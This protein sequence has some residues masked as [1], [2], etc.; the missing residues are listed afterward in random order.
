VNILNN[1]K[2]NS[3][4]NL[5][6]ENFIN[7]N[8]QEIY[9]FFYNQAQVDLYKYKSEIKQY[10]RQS[11]NQ[12]RFLNCSNKLNGD[13]IALIVETC[14]KLH[15]YMEFKIFYDYLS[16]CGY[17][18]GSRLESTHYYCSG[19]KKFDDYYD[20]YPI[21]LNL[22]ENAYIEEEDSKEKLTAT[23]INFYLHI[24]Y[25]FGGNNKDGVV[26]LKNDISNKLKEFV[27]LDKELINIIFNISIDDFKKA[28]NDIIR[29]LNDYLYQN[30]LI[31][32]YLYDDIKIE[33]SEY[34]QKLQEVHNLTFD[35]IFQ[36]SKHYVEN[37]I[38][39]EKKIHYSLKRG[40]KILDEEE[41][42]YQ[43][44]KSF[45]KMHKAK[46]YSSF[47]T[48]INELNTQTINIIDWGCG[49]A[50]ATSLLIDYIKEK[51]LKI[52]I[53]NITLIEPSQL[54]LSR[55]LLHID[56]LKENPIKIRAINKDIDCLEINDLIIENLNI[57]L[58]LFSNIL[59]V[60][61]FKL[62]KLFLEKVSSSQRGMNYFIC[63]SPNIND[64]RNARLD[65]FYRYFSDNF[66]TEL[67]S[68][69]DTNIKD[70]SRY[71]K[72]FKSN[73]QR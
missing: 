57:T 53:S 8:F 26:N 67:I 1:L 42:L 52:N 70:Y 48:I 58:H 68:N 34:S 2:H 69:R 50:L 39:D 66:N 73:I 18:L 21:I 4:T 16:K 59:D 40:I 27:S 5:Q 54:A 37:N 36:I 28:Y 32:C 43:Y 31:S 71:E 19:I 33:V 11:K 23:F 49:Q 65:M 14:E 15:L 61:F 51:N 9:D 56:V 47:D 3:S 72:I 55:G 44:I 25:N 30:D 60:E 29:I 63:V 46:L 41:E 7:S 64:K 62:D 10:F 38:E 20:R 45:G 22:L 6:L 24:L 17:T 13:F 35:N 12:I